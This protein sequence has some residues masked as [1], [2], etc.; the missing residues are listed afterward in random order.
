MGTLHKKK[1]C[2]EGLFEFWEVTEP[3]SQCSFITK[4]YGVKI[5]TKNLMWTEVESVDCIK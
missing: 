5:K 3:L 4:C 2:G 1:F